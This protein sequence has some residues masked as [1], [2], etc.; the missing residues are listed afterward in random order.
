MM[1]VLI[2]ACAALTLQVGFY[3]MEGV[4]AE[5]LEEVQTSA[6]TPFRHAGIEIAWTTY[7]KDR[8]GAWLAGPAGDCATVP[9]IRVR[10]LPTRD[11]RDDSSLGRAYLNAN[12][13]ATTIDI[14]YPPIEALGFQARSGTY[15][16]LAALTLRSTMAAILSAALAHE[17]GHALL[18]ASH[19]A[20]GVMGSPHTQWDWEAMF[21]GRLRFSPLQETVLRNEAIARMLAGQGFPETSSCDFSDGLSGN[22]KT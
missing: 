7:R 14:Y 15:G 2:A 1:A 11:V 22:S 9:E 20:E 4:S 16:T 21:F 18:G 5:L 13:F 8:Q 12:S 3:D 19:T 17:L 10:L 6:V